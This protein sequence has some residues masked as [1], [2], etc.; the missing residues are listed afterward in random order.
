MIID[1]SVK[2]FKS[3]QDEAV[4]SFVAVNAYDE[5]PEYVSEIS[6]PG[7]GDVKLLKVMGLFGAN[8]SGKSSILEALILMFSLVTGSHKNEINEEIERDYFKLADNAE[9]E[10]TEMCLRFI[11]EGIRCHFTVELNSERI[12]YECLE[13][14][15]KGRSQTWY[16]R[17]WNED[18]KAYDWGPKASEFYKIET[19]RKANTRNNVLYLSKAVD[20]NDQQ[21][22]PIFSWFKKNYGT[23]QDLWGVTSISKHLKENPEV[24]DFLNEHIRTA[25]LGVAQVYLDSKVIKRPKSLKR[26]NDKSYVLEEDDFEKLV[27]PILQFLHY[28]NS[29]KTVPLNFD[30]QSGGTQELV[31]IYSRLHKSLEI[32]E[33]EVSD[34]IENELH[35]LMARHFIKLFTSDLNQNGAQLLFTSHDAT[36][37]DN[38]FM[39]RDQYWF[40]EKDK[41]GRS[42]LKS[43]AEFSVKK[44]KVLM[45]AYLSGV[46]G[47]IPQLTKFISDYTDELVNAE[48]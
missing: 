29:G 35:P 25:D 1:F 44:G 20:D 18:Q 16:E 47:A 28:S 42:T 24:L 22:F 32:G 14:F 8:A 31:K 4:L 5:H 13:V 21:L 23:N 17:E 30:E 41:Y 45:Q 26:Q 38:S 40:T 9:D 34:E 15:P 11:C 36:L 19:N 3:F 27:V 2:N 43:L 7:M 39:R 37:L 33:F 10:P 12:L 46:Y 48:D 6:L